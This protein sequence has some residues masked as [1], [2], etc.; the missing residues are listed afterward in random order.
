MS[1]H[2]P[3][4]SYT[5]GGGRNESQEQ[6]QRLRATTAFSPQG[7]ARVASSTATGSDDINQ[8]RE[9]AQELSAAAAKSDP[10]VDQLKR[11]LERCKSDQTSLQTKLESALEDPNIGTNLELIFSVNE[12]LL[13]AIAKGKE[14]Y[15][16]EKKKRKKKKAIEGPSIELLVVNE[17]VFSLICMLRAPSEKRL[18]AS[19]ALMKFAKENAMLRN[20]IRSSGGMHSF[21]TL[22]RGKNTSGELKV[23]SA[24]A[25]AYVLPMFVTKSTVTNALAGKFLECLRFLTVADP[26]SPQDVVISRKEMYNAASDGVNALWNNTIK[27]LVAIQ[28][29][30]TEDEVAT[31]TLLRSTSSRYLRT[32]ARTSVQNQEGS[33]IKVLMETSVTLI[34]NIAK[35]TNEMNIDTAYDIVADVCEVDVARSVSVREGLLSTIIEW[36]R[37]RNL[38]KM[39][40]AAEALRHLISIEDQYVAGWIHSQLVNEGAVNEIVKL[41][42]ESISANVREA[43]AQMISVLCQTAQTRTAVVEARCVSY[44]VALLYEH[45]EPESENMVNYAASAL[46]RLAGGGILQGEASSQNYVASNDQESV[47][48]CVDYE[49]V[50]ESLLP[51]SLH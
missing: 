38:F 44:L 28:Q 43:V 21:L 33:E 51:P 31:P 27:A 11:L 39:R 47:V 9:D 29:S 30:K 3:Y 41:F 48:R 10:D 40:P 15:K 19:L 18:A 34:T 36:L 50:P 14:I 4:T 45:N 32:R 5:V 7:G 49:K 17:D 26:V 42:N 22:F 25:V 12:E 35:A 8:A 20:E 2:N 13:N 6:T 46:L 24:M 16:S 1:N 23:V 37:S